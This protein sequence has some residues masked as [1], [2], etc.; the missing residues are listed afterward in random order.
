M[1][2]CAM[3]SLYI[4]AGLEWLRVYKFLNKAKMLKKT[5]CSIVAISLSLSSYAQFKNGFGIDLVLGV[6][7]EHYGL[8]KGNRYPVDGIPGG[9]QFGLKLSSVW[10]IYK[11]ELLAAGIN[12]RWWD[13]YLGQKTD[14][15]YR[16]R[17]FDM[18]LMGAGPIVS[19]NLGNEM[20][21]D[22]YYN[23]RP[24]LMVVPMKM[25][26]IH[27]GWEG[28]GSAFASGIGHSAGA[29]F[30]FKILS[31]GAEYSF[32]NFSGDYIGVNLSNVDLPHDNKVFISANSFRVN[33]GLRL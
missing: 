23:F 1:C 29:T 16:I 24:A 32:G 28:E 9:A 33:I 5:L 22:A 10:Y 30:R 2:L 14:T 12:A 31:I 4:F 27:Y 3:F 20:Y 18:S 26:D 13:I 6:P 19:V 17:T 8:D 11:D 25:H 7:S 15:R 21:F